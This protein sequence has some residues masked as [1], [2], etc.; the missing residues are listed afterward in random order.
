MT[1]LD[2]EVGHRAGWLVNSLIPFAA[3]AS[4]AVMDD[5]QPDKIA[6][7]G[8][9]VNALQLA[10]RALFPETFTFHSTYNM[11]EGESL[12]SSPR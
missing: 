2:D 5:A 4:A 11:T 10:F 7:I 9:D 1:L 12:E 3:A 8:C 6:L